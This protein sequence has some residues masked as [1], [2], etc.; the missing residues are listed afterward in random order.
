MGTQ[1][2]QAFALIK[3]QQNP[4]NQKKTFFS[5]PKNLNRR[6]PLYSGIPRMSSPNYLYRNHAA[7][8]YPGTGQAALALR[9]RYLQKVQ[10]CHRAPAYQ[11][12]L[13]TGT[14]ITCLSE[15]LLNDKTNLLNEDHPGG[16]LGSW[17]TV[18]RERKRARA[19]S[20]E[21]YE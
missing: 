16:S 15:P 4:T 17:Q 12:V 1:E 10:E 9:S 8:L 14:V 5:E 19:P 21:D 7:E 11:I 3:N 2:G 6:A 20:F 13:P 18:R